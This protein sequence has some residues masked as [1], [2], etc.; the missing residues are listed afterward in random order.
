MSYSAEE[1]YEVYNERR[2]VARKPFECDC[3]ICSV[4]VRPGDSYTRVTTIY[5]GRVDTIRRCMRCQYLHEHL[6]CL[7]AANSDGMW[8][9]ERLNCGLDYTEEWGD[10][11]VEI[12]ALA[13]W[14]PGDK[15]PE[16]EPCT[17]IA[18]YASQASWIAPGCCP[19]CYAVNTRCLPGCIDD[20]M[21]QEREERICDACAEDCFGV[22]EDE[23]D[24]PW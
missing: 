24:R 18:H 21:R 13:F 1:Q 6:R 17:T 4:V 19:G 12:A 20:E 10:L 23:D 16:T 2:I 9:D 15:L 11:S 3:V 22:G 14:Q 7:C 8:P 5:D